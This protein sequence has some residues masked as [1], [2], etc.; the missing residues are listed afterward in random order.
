MLAALGL[1]C[2]G[3]L[4]LGVVSGDCSLVL[5]LRLLIVM[6]SLAVDGAQAPELAGFSS[7]D[8]WLSWP[9]SMWSNQCLLHC[10]ENSYPLDHQGSSQNHWDISSAR[11]VLGRTQQTGSYTVPCLWV[12]TCNQPDGCVLAE[13]L[14]LLF[15]PFL[16]LLNYFSQKTCYWF[17]CSLIKQGISVALQ[18]SFPAFKQEAPPG[19]CFP[20][21]YI[22]LIHL[23]RKLN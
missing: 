22:H 23:G 2:F 4:S 11:T 7:L 5:V 8:P 19:S 3:G 16:D 10:N 15:S 6:A 20:Y 13:N 14:S 21:Q 12:R 1:C 9:L 17:L 18:A